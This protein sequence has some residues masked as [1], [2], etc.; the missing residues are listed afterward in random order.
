MSKGH[1]FTNIPGIPNAPGFSCFAPASPMLLYARAAVLQHHRAPVLPCS[2]YSCTPGTPVFLYHRARNRLSCS[3]DNLGRHP[4]EQNKPSRSLD[5]L[6][7]P[8]REQIE[9]FRSRDNLGKSS[10]EQLGYPCAREGWLVSFFRDAPS[11]WEEKWSPN[12]GA[13]PLVAPN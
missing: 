5:N 13:V 7:R 1:K 3:R 4:R 12:R 8:S 11:H 9:P 6:G 2:R 10:R